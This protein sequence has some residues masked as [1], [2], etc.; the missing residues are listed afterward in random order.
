MK[1]FPDFEKAAGEALRTAS[2]SGLSDR[3]YSSVPK[4][5]TFPLLLVRRIGGLPAVRQYL[6][7]A[8]LQIDVWGA[9]KSEARLI[10]AESRTVL[11]AMEGSDVGDVWVSGVEDS[12]GLSWQP[13]PE[14][15]RDRYVFA[16]N[17]YGRSLTS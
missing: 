2:I 12:L 8:N 15:G 17:V 4:S 9:S 6:D 7:A 10:A 16:V 1:D 3:V 11:F 14:T 13:D 5:P